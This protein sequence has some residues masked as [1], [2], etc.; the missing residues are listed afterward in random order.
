MS[1]LTRRP[2]HETVTVRTTFVDTP[3]G[4]ANVEIAGANAHHLTV[5]HGVIHAIILRRY[6]R[7]GF[8]GMVQLE[9]EN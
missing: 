2:V 3:G 9:I 1:G 5:V 8:S 6:F 4:F 7:W